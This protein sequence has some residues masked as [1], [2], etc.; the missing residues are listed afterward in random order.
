[1]GFGAFR[2]V[3]VPVLHAVHKCAVEDDLVT[4]QKEKRIIATLEPVI[5]RGALIVTTQAIEQDKTDC[6]RYSPKDRQVYS[7]FFQLAKLTPER[8]ALV[9]D[10]RADALEG[11]V[12]YWQKYLAVDQERLATQERERALKEML[13]DPLGVKRYDPPQRMGRSVFNKYIR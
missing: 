8:G 10:D 1:M 9:H 11:A 2:E 13:D 3:F 5:G 6:A 7:L 4:G 12:R